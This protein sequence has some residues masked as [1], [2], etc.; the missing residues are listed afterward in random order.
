VVVGTVDA[1]AAVPW[2]VVVVAA[3]VLLLPQAAMR[4]PRLAHNTTVRRLISWVRLCMRENAS[5]G[6]ARGSA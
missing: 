1:W 6:A 5:P 3:T 2:V 4:R